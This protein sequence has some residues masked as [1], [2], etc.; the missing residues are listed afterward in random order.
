[1]VNMCHG[2]LQSHQLLSM[3]KLRMAQICGM[4][5]TELLSDVDMIYSSYKLK[6][7]LEKGKMLLATDG[8]AGDDIMSFVWK[9]CNTEGQTLI[10]HA[11]PTFGKES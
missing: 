9:I 5:H 3:L 1:M 4:A 11:D 6:E 7:M 10:Q 2:N 8:S